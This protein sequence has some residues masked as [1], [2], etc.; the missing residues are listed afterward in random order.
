MNFIV[1]I[2]AFTYKD[3]YTLLPK[4]VAV[5]AVHKD[6]LAHWIVSPPVPYSTLRSVS[7][8]SNTWLCD[9]HHGIDWIEEGISL[10]QLHSNL[11]RLARVASTITVYTKDV[12]DYLQDIVG[13][14]IISLEEDPETPAFCKLKPQD[15]FCIYHGVERAQI[16][17]CALNNVY[18]VREYILRTGRTI[19]DSAIKTH[20]KSIKTSLISCKNKSTQT[21]DDSEDYSEVYETAE[22]EPQYI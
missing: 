5:L 20:N 15:N 1:D 10:H 19:Q 7:K 3:N 13:R 21:S 9:N 17:R 12:A 14:S 22:E 8:L 16:Y 6:Y 11:R 18:R 2:Q 4:E